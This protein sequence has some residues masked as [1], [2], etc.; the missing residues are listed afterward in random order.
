M[1]RIS[2][3]TIVPADAFDACV[4]GITDAALSERFAAARADVVA[5]FELY[6][7]HAKALRLHSL[8]ASERAQDKQV[9]LAEITKQEFVALYSY[10]MV[11]AGKPGRAYYDKIMTLAHLNKCP[12]CRFGTVTTL[13]HFLPK[14]NYPAF[15]VLPYNLIPACKDCNTKKG[16]GVVARDSELPH[17]YFEVEAIETDKWLYVEFSQTHPIE[18]RYVFRPPATWQPDLSRRMGNYFRDMNLAHRFGIQAASEIV[19]WHEVLKQTPPEQRGAHLALHADVE[20]N[21]GRN[22]WRA[23]LLDALAASNW[24]AAEGYLL[25]QPEEVV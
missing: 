9:V 15:S 18:P 22:T 2:K 5:N 23:A 16:S 20:R 13:D 11:G 1:K 19:Y 8:A 25:Q 7:A 24:Y 4:A 17:P 6:D 3:P 21:L 12:F 10:Y 14:S